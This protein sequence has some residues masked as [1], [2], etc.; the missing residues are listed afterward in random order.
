MP[1]NF[2]LS[3]LF[4]LL[5]SFLAPAVAAEPM[6]LKT[7]EGKTVVLY[8]DFTWEFKRPAPGALDDTVDLNALVTRPGDFAGQDIV[9]TGNVARLLGAYR[10]KSTEEQNNIVVDVE[11]V[12][13]ADQI[14]L[15]KAIEAK[16]L[17]GSVRLQIQANVGR[18]NL[19]H[20]LVASDIVFVD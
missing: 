14:E 4:L 1:K 2:I 19:V 10:L 6:E 16:G 17:G 12:R 18:R 20:R 13:R 8:P 3:G 9:V 5:C 11:G 15:E 7:P